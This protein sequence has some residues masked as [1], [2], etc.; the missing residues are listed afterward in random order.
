[1]TIN[2]LRCDVCGRLLTG[3]A[4]R[5]AEPASPAQAS[6]GSAIESGRPDEVPHE[7]ARPDG[8]PGRPDGVRFVYHPGRPELRDTS[9][10]ACQACWDEAVRPFGGQ[11]GQAAGRCAA[12][13]TPVGRLESLHLRRYDDPRAWRLCA[14]DAVDFLNRLR[15]VEPKLDPATFRF[16]FADDAARDF[17]DVDQA[18]TPD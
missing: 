15:T 17:G 16:P 3:L 6:S 4:D 1:M 8:L 12:C 9:G 7:A 13:G 2:D 10:L 18:G 14:P 5:P 11:Q